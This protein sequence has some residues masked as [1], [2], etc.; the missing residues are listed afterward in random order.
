[1]RPA[2]FNRKQ[3][4]LFIFWMGEQLA[5]AATITSASPRTHSLIRRRGK[6]ELKADFM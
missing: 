4:A 5:G 6:R 3:A 1:M 2:K